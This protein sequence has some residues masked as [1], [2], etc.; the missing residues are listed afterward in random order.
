MLKKQ[1]VKEN[2]NKIIEVDGGVNTENAG[3]LIES[4]AEALVV[5]SFIFKSEDPISTIKNLKEIAL[6]HAI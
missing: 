5:G 4:G 2:L 3:K 1:L 6:Q